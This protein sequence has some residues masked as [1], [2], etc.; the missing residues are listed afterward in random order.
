MISQGLQIRQLMAVS[1]AVAGTSGTGQNE[2]GLFQSILGKMFGGR[3]SGFSTKGFGDKQTGL[4]LVDR[5]KR[6]L[7]YKGGNLDNMTVDRNTLNILQGILKAAGFDGKQ[8]ADLMDELNALHKGRKLKLSDLFNRLEAL[9]KD[10]ASEEDAMAEISSLP[11]L[12]SILASLGL[13]DAD[14]SKVLGDAK[15]EGEGID[16]QQLL[17]GLKEIAAGKGGSGRN[18]G[19]AGS[20]N[21]MMSQ[22]GAGRG[23]ADSVMDL[24]SF[25]AELEALLANRSKLSRTNPQLAGAVGHFVGNVKRQ[26]ESGLFDSPQE[27][28]RQMAAAALGEEKVGHRSTRRMKDKGTG[29]RVPEPGKIL[30]KPDGDILLAGQ[31][32]AALAAEEKPFASHSSWELANAFRAGNG[33]KTEDGSLRA[34]LARLERE[35]VDISGLD[36]S[37]G[38][39]G[40]DGK[41]SAS[42]GAGAPKTL[43]AYVLYQVS[44]QMLRAAQAGMREIQ[45]QLKPPHLGRIHMS[46]ENV[47]DGLRVSII[48]EHQAAREM[49]AGNAAELRSALLDSGLRLEKIDIQLAFNF[50]QSMAQARQDSRRSMNRRQTG[51]QIEGAT[52]G[53]REVHG[54]ASA[55]LW[56]RNGILDLVA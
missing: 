4:S 8:I 7:L 38:L 15:I 35:S 18:A 11:F 52:E 41:S 10:A 23:D 42:S 27:R 45:L 51:F 17:A 53:V 28:M 36:Q 3:G 5:L 6:A 56:R 47:K 22:I 43:P 2:G 46:L 12:E 32:K 55:T 31:N 50:D 1:A 13:T 14:I 44:R 33:I 25:I 30:P 29:V 54:A 37:S 39:K 24:A 26:D 16:L 20:V 21:E 9:E 49:L 34:G 19:D 48:T 40:A